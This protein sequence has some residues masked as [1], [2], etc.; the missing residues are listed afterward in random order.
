MASSLR[1]MFRASLLSAV[2]L[3]PMPAASESP[4]S[5]EDARTRL[6][7]LYVPID[8][9]GLV[10]AALQG[11]VTTVQLLLAAGVDPNAR[12]ATLPQSA[13]NAA[14]MRSCLPGADAQVRD[15]MVDALLAAG[16]DPNATE[17]AGT[18]TLTMIAQRCPGTV[19]QK[20]LAA[21]GDPAHRSPQGFGPLSMALTVR[22]LDAAE[23]LVEH[24]VRLPAATLQRLFPEPPEDPRLARVIER[25][26]E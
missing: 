17:G 24:G 21:G 11:R 4:V 5:A 13:L 12:S 1:A 10:Q 23:A 15:A 2:I 19:V 8:A 18:S 26:R 25:A 16:A 3:L 20:L 22:N 6:Q 9:D 7:A 14:T